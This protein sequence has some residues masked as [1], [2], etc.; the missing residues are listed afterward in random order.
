M[1]SDCEPCT[2]Y[3]ETNVAARS[4]TRC[5]ACREKI[6]K[7]AKY[8]RIA[9]LFDGRW[10][11]VRRCQ[12]CQAIHLH[13]RSVSSQHD[14]WPDDTLSCGHSYRDAHGC[15]PPESI[16]RLAFALPCEVL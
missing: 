11:T 2:I 12:R 3:K 7:A 10:T 9:I 15:E 16:A 4:D 6:V 8:W 14:E 13:L 5:S 1:D